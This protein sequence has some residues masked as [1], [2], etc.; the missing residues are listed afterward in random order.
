MS[1]SDTAAAAAPTRMP[2]TATVTLDTP[3]ER[4][5]QRITEL[6]LRK[7]MSGELRGIALADL[8]RLDVGA[9][10]ALLPRITAPTLTVHDVQQLDPADLVQIGGEVVGFF[11]TRADRAAAP[12]PGLH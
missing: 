4:G 12:T 6:T 2:V 9:L 5:E 11:M 7:P 10:H 3:I 1:K 8:L